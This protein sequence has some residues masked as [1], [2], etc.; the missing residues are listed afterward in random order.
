MR[1]LNAWLHLM[2]P[3]ALIVLAVFVRVQNIP[4]VLEAQNRIFDQFQ[5]I[6]PRVYEPAAVKIIDLDDE[7][8]TRIGQWPWPR[9]DVAKMIAYLA[10]AGA[11]VIAFDIVFAEPDRTSPS[12]ILPVWSEFTPDI[13]QRFEGAELYDH[14]AILA[15]IIAQTSVVTGFVLADD[16]EDGAPATKASYAFA[17]DDPLPE[18]FGFSG[19]VTNLPAIEEAASGNG[20]FNLIS[21]TDNIVRRV[22]LVLKTG[23]QMHLS[24]SAEA[25]RVAQAARNFI[26][27]SAGA[28]MEEAYGE[29]TGINHVKIGRIE[30]PTDSKAR[31][32]IHFTDFVPER[33]IPA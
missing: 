5:I 11:A 16:V 21:E 31:I 17:G 18:L 3:P 29:H 1:R 20:S 33:Y 25:I 19:A 13:E 32:W 22:P 6:Q 30:V 8:L 10:N 2:V 4:I 26:V 15:D 7:S 27:K 24:L 28:N 23:D 14:D 12:Q 9:T